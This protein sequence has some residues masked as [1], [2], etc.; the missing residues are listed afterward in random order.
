MQ[1]TVSRLLRASPAEFPLRFERVDLA[2]LIDRG[3]DHHR[4][5]ARERNLEIV[6]RAAG[7][8]PPVWADRVATAVVADVLLT[9]AILASSPDGDIVVQIVSGPGGAVCTISDN[10][11]LSPIQAA[12]LLEFSTDPGPLP[13][14]V[15]GHAVHGVAIAKRFVERMGGRLWS[16]S[17]PGRGTTMSFRLPYHPL[18]KHA[19]EPE[20]NAPGS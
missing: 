19:G 17:E 16:E 14:D 1:H 8:V 7:D 2:V 13:T 6:C 12:R 20:G 11:G 9:N 4:R 15:E 3:C 18:N 10:R 5:L